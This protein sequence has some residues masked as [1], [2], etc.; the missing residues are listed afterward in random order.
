MTHTVHLQFDNI[1]NT[2]LQRLT[3]ALDNNLTILA[4]ALDIHISRRFADFTF[5]GDFAH[6]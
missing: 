6:A 1:D 4:K 5:M 3:G 2:V